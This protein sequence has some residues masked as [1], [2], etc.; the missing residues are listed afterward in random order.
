MKLYCHVLRYLSET[1]LSED[2]F[3][4]AGLFVTPTLPQMFKISLIFQASVFSYV[5]F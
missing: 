4:F 3:V 2:I 5:R 1:G